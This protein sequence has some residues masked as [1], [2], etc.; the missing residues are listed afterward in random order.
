MELCIRLSVSR[1]LLCM[2]TLLEQQQERPFPGNEKCLKNLSII[3]EECEKYP[4]ISF[5]KYVHLLGMKMEDS[6]YNCFEIHSLT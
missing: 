5:K 4:V 6:C 1:R 2:L 3:Q